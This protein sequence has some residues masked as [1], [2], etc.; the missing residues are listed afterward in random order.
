[1]TTRTITL[2]A[3][4]WQRISETLENCYDEGPPG[5]GWRSGELSA[6]AAALNAALEQPEPDQPEPPSYDE[7]LDEYVRAD[8][9]NYAGDQLE[10][11]YE[12]FCDGWR[13]ALNADWR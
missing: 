1:M 7:W 9:W 10:Q 8:R 3:E 5:E 12:G 4:H 6:A 11:Q 2:S 13:C